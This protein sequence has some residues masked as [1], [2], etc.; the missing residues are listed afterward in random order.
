MIFLD[1]GF[2]FALFAERDERH[3]RAMEAFEV[4]AGKRLSQLILMTNHVVVETITLTRVRGHRD[5][6]MSHDLAIRVGRQLLAGTFG[7]IHHATAGEEREA[8]D[9]LARHRDQRYSFVDCL[10]FVVME[11]QGIREALTFDEHFSHRFIVRP[12]IT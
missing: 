6:G 4:F 1:T 12:G 5:L 7:R 9:Y 3:S 10:S 11:R 2:L 8:F